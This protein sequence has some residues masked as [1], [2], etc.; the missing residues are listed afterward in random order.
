VEHRG[1]LSRIGV[2]LLNLL[3]PGLGLLRLGRWKIAATAF[4]AALMF[5]TFIYSAPP[6]DFLVF[7]GVAIVGLAVYPCSIGATWYLSRSV[8]RPRRWFAQWYSVVAAMMLFLVVSYIVGDEPRYHS[9]YAPAEGMSPT[10]P[11]G[12]RF[13]AYM[14]MPRELRRGDVLLV[15]APDG[16]TYVKRLAALP[17]DEIAVTDEKVSING[18][19]V[20]LQPMSTETVSDSAGTRTVRRLRE[21]FPGESGSH[22]I[23]DDGDTIGD[24]FGPQRVRSDHIFLLGDNRDHSTDSRFSHEQFGLEQLPITDILGW[25]L[26]HSFGSSHRIGERISR[27]DMK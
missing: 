14:R 13:F 8:D 19:P 11:S 6:V 23:Y 24:N 22:D 21:R 5:V 25:P 2:S 20:T 17:G 9:F 15:R 16:S 4:V 10:L 27:E 1:V 12:D 18:K 7:A 26:F 3:A